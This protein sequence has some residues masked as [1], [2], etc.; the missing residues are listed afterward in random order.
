MWP[1]G[2]SVASGRSSRERL[3]AQALT[4]S[5]IALGRKNHVPIQ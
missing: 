3:T 5:P 4:S 2:P 1:Y